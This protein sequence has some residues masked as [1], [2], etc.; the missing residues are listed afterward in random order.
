[1]TRKQASSRERQAGGRR[2][3]GRPAL[4]MFYG[5]PGEDLVP[6]PPEPEGK[7]SPGTAMFYSIVETGARNGW[8]GLGQSQ[9]HGI[10]SIEACTSYGKA[11]LPPQVERDVKQAVAECIAPAVKGVPQDLRVPG[12]GGDCSFRIWFR[13][14]P[15]AW[16]DD[17]KDIDTEKRDEVPLPSPR[18]RGEL[19]KA[20]AAFRELV[21]EFGSER[22]RQATRL[23]PVLAAYLRRWEEEQERPTEESKNRSADEIAQAKKEL[24]ERV[25]ECLNA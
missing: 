16:I 14:L 17:N 9:R 25:N 3:T 23:Q 13:A 12:E 22:E 24:V 1:M 21:E 20:Q 8:D 7:L 18:S 10:I 4:L 11:A 6:W 15:L 2:R 5:R 19:E